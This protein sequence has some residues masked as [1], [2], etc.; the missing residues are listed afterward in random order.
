MKRVPIPKEEL[1]KLTHLHHAVD[2]CA[3]ALIAHWL[4]KNGK[5]WELLALGEL[6][7]SEKLQYD[8]LVKEFAPGKLEHFLTCYKI[9]T[10]KTKRSPDPKRIYRL[11]PKRTPDAKARMCRIRDQ[12]SRELAKKRV[13][14][15]I[16]AEHAGLPTDETIY[17]AITG[18]E[19]NGK[20]VQMVRDKIKEQRGKVAELEKPLRE[21]EGKL[22]EFDAEL[23]SIP[24]KEQRKLVKAERKNQRDA[25]ASELKKAKAKHEAAKEVLETME[26]FQSNAW[27]IKRVRIGSDGWTE[28]KKRLDKAADTPVGTSVEA[29]TTNHNGEDTGEKAKGKKPPKLLGKPDLE[30]DKVVFVFDMISRKKLISLKP[31]KGAKE[32]GTNFGI[33]ILDNV[34]NEQEKFVVIPWHKVWPRI[35]G[36]KSVNGE[37]SFL[38]R[39]AGQRPRIIRV[40]TLIRLKNTGKAEKDGVWMVR[41]VKASLKLD[42]SRVDFIQM[43]KDPKVW[44]EVS[45]AT[46]GAANIEILPNKL[47]GVPQ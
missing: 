26:N 16:P 8:A 9:D 23:E 47:T 32:I 33:A 37:K 29:D 43:I 18:V 38:E 1:R 5:L 27:L 31:L 22:K 35:Y 12:I 17:R 6:T 30:K 14:Q 4:P 24:D 7:E 19:G 11:E 2:A 20:I 46:L 36:P 21:C 41:S 45:L 44:R 34:P 28:I 25:L 3:L 39:N 15:H 42:L 10:T 40:G 13:V